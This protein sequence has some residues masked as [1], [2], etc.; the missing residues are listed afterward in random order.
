MIGVPVTLVY[1]IQ[2][3]VVLF[4]LARSALEHGTFDRFLRRLKSA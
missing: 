2:A 1:I 3:L 4:V